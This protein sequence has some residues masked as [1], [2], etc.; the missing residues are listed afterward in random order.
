MFYTKL[1]R[2]MMSFGL[3]T[4]TLFLIRIILVSKSDGG[5]FRSDVRGLGRILGHGLPPGRA[6]QLALRRSLR[7]QEK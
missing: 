3:K 5:S 1:Y 4:L 7:T 2:N 6:R